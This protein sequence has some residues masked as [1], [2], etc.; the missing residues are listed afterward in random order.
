MTI[1]PDTKRAVRP[2]QETHRQ[3][4]LAML[5]ARSVALVGASP[6]P[7]SFGQ[8][9][10]EEVSRSPAR[11]RI[12]LVNPEKWTHGSSAQRQTWFK[13]GYQSGDPD[14]C[15]TFGGRI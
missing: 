10:I 15:D 12:H 14:A 3:A 4:I 6:R 1:D 11:P 2:A 5:E 13:T 9:M 7:G 8:R